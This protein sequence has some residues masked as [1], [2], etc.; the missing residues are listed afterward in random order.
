MN[1]SPSLH[2]IVGGF[3]FVYPCL[4]PLSNSTRRDDPRRSFFSTFGACNIPVQVMSLINL[5]LSSRRISPSAQVNDW[6]GLR[7]TSCTFPFTFCL[8]RQESVQEFNEGM[9]RLR[10]IAIL[11][12]I[13]QSVIDIVN[14]VIMWGKQRHIFEIQTMNSLSPHLRVGGDDE[15]KFCAAP[16]SGTIE[17]MVP[18]YS[19]SVMQ[20]ENIRMIVG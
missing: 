5:P 2:W 7:K 19:Y 20:N 1:I 10:G 3:E 11:H 6:P 17:R 8:I 15:V 4:K 18:E 9:N 16:V 13:F 14:D 12:N